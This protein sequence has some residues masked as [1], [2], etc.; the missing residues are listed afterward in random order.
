[1]SQPV[2]RESRSERAER[3]RRDS[4]RLGDGMRAHSSS[5][6]CAVIGFFFLGFIFGPMAIYFAWK[7][8]KYY[9]PAKFGKILGWIDT[10]I[11]AFWIWA[12]YSFMYHPQ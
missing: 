4:D 5:S 9:G 3:I 7:S 11:G 1:M 8:E 12:I 6:L 2:D 10:F